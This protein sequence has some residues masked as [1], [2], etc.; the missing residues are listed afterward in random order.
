MTEG[1][2]FKETN[3]YRKSFFHDVVELAKKVSIHCCTDVTI[4]QSWQRAKYPQPLASRLAPQEMNIFAMVGRIILQSLE[5]HSNGTKHDREVHDAGTALSRFVDKYDAL[6]LNHKKRRPLVILAFDES[7]DLTTL[8]DV[9]NRF[10]FPEL[11][12]VLNAL[13]TLPI[14][15]LFISTNSPVTQFDRSSTHMVN[16]LPP[17]T[18]TNFDQLAHPAVEGKVTLS[19]VVTDE[20][21]CHLGRPLY[22][23]VS[24]FTLLGGLSPSSR[25]FGSRYDAGQEGGPVRSEILSFA[26]FKLLGGMNQL[27]ED[28]QDLPTSRLDRTLACFSVRV[29]LEFNSTD[30][31][32]HALVRKQVAHQMQL[33]ITATS[34]SEQLFT[35]VGSEPLLAEA[36]S[37]GLV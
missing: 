15:S 6:G 1:Q 28:E 19:D 20:W 32:V 25:R 18:E 9:Q 36:A 23:L 3:P 12:R 30:K 10:I 31:A 37:Q 16:A 4:P 7:H 22:V 26:K 27:D 29:P 13:V 14:F 5:F 24:P 33:C 8:K 34:G 35:T 17:T 11:H 21:M 2:K